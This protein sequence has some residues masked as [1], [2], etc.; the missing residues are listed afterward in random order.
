[1]FS[2]KG[3]A[4]TTSLGQRPRYLCHVERW[5]CKRDSFRDPPEWYWPRSDILKRAFS[6]WSLSRQKTLGRS[7]RLGWQRAFGA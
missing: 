5:R 4:F 6:A 7:P 2:A 1:M 3:A